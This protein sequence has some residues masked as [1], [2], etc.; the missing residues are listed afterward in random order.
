MSDAQ[1]APPE[2]DRLFYYICEK[3]AELLRLR[4]TELPP[5]WNMA[6]LIHTLIG[7][8]A[9]QIPDL[10]KDYYYDLILR[11]ESSWLFEDLCNFLDLIN[12]A[13]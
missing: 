1:S 9:L 6:D 10:L 13:L 2:L 12:Y 3:S 11:G 8:D 7:D 5:E 4:S